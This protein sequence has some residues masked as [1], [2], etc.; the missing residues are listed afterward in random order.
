MMQKEVLVHWESLPSSKCGRRR[1]DYQKQTQSSTSFLSVSLCVWG[2]GHCEERREVLYVVYIGKWVAQRERERGDDDD[3]DDEVVGEVDSLQGSV[4][5]WK[6]V[7]NW[8]ILS[9]GEA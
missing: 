4:G 3:D 2:N 1:Q 6:S 7:D 8:C 9:T 5:A